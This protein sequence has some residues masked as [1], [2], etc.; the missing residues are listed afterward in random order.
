MIEH[1]LTDGAAD[2][3]ARAAALGAVPDPLEVRESPLPGG[4]YDLVVGDLLYSQLLYPALLDLGVPA[5]R[6][7]AFLQRYGDRL[8]RAV[9]ARLHTSAP[10]RPVVHLHDPLAW[11]P[12]HR[13]TVSLRDILALAQ[14]D[15]AAALRL[16]AEGEGPR[17]CDP[18]CALARFRIPIHRTE[19]WRWAF[20]GDTDYLVCASV[21]GDVPGRAARP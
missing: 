17:E 19:M 11:S 18:R 4:P 14:R 13:Q 8:T 21:A 16:A 3:V 20:A 1:D 5:A 2:A 12:G 6:R 7:R 9:V 10:N 15:P